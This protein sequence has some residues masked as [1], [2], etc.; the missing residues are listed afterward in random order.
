MHQCL[1]PNGGVFYVVIVSYDHRLRQ[2]DDCI[3]ET[4]EKE[5]PG[6]WGVGG[7]MGREIRRNWER[8][9]NA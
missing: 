6:V 8:G 4:Q 9:Q 3:P 1:S 5:Q 2:P 7:Q